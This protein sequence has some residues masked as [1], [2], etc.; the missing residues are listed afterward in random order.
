MGV[1]GGLK[2]VFLEE[3]VILNMIDFPLRGMSRCCL[4]SIFSMSEILHVLVLAMIVQI[5]TGLW[6][7]NGLAIW[8]QLLHYRG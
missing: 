8:G 1:Q 5:R 4:I 2:G 6:V 3:Q 7:R